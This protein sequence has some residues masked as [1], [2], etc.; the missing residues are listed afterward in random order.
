MATMKELL[1]ALRSMRR[2]KARDD[3]G[4]VAEMLKDSSASFLEATLKLFNDILVGQVAASKAWKVS[5]LVLV[6]KN[7]LATTARS[8]SCRPFTNFSARY[9]AIAFLN[10][11]CWRRESS[12]LP[13]GRATAL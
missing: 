5:R 13:T 11:V 3:S 1:E 6:F 12:K 9:S 7:W 8:P 2:G 4:V 10:T